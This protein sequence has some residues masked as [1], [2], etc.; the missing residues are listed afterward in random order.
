M[1]GTTFAEPLHDHHIS[2]NGDD[3]GH[4]RRDNIDDIRIIMHN[5]LP[6]PS[7]EN[8]VYVNSVKISPF[9]HE[10]DI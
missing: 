1:N 5:C 7:A 9:P 2:S 6:R 8:V 4:F 10:G 3:F